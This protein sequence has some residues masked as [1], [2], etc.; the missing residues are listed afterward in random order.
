MFTVGIIK[1]N[2]FI[3]NN[4]VSFEY[5]LNVIK[6]Y[7][8]FV[9]C[10]DTEH[11]MEIIINNTQLSSDIMGNTMTCYEYTDCMIQIC[12][13]QTSNDI[14]GIASYLVYS[15]Y[16]LNG[17]CVI[18]KTHIDSDNNNKFSPDSITYFDIAN[19]LFKHICHY[20]IIYN[21]DDSISSF[22]FMND[23]MELFNNSD[24]IK[25]FD[26]NCLGFVLY[27]YVNEND[28]S[29]INN[30]ISKIYGKPIYGNVYISLKIGQYEFVDITEDVFNKFFTVLTHDKYNGLLDD[31]EKLGIHDDTVFNPWHLLNH[32]FKKLNCTK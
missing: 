9:E 12:S 27:F 19:V 17:T 15:K 16:Q 28:S 26:I 24:K 7:I 6:D 18:L 10:S 30:K 20:G 3:I 2:N 23:P 5:I 31:G 21:T 14:N 11:M 29:G 25:Y 32:R 8:I 1:P 4:S 22:T 13:N